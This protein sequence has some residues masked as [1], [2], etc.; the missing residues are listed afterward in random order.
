MEPAAARRRSAA[1]SMLMKWEI[2]KTKLH[3]HGTKISPY[4]C[5]WSFLPFLFI[6]FFCHAHALIWL[7]SGDRKT[8]GT[9]RRD[10]ILFFTPAG[11]GDVD[12]KC[13][14]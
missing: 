9:S 7:N 2:K 11:D 5:V 10:G 8:C 1:I 14:L 4:L 13:Q 3:L 6:Y 12:R